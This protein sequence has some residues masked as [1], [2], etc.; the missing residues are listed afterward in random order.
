[1]LLLIVS[2]NNDFILK[3]ILAEELYAKALQIFEICLP[4]INNLCGKADT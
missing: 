1:M 2:I 4:L 3:F